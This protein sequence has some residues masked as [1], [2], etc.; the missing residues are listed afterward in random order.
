MK[1]KKKSSIIYRMF[2]C[3]L[4]GIT[5]Y[6]TYICEDCNK[7][8]KYIDLYSKEVVLDGLEKLFTRNEEQREHKVKHIKLKD[9]LK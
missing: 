8:R 3:K 7:V 2:D 6:T 4:C 5:C 9:R 1:S